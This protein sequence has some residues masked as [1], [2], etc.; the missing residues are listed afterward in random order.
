MFKHKTAIRR[1]TS[2][3]SDIS[4]FQ[5][6][7]IIIDKSKKYQLSR[8]II[9]DILTMS[10]NAINKTLTPLIIILLEQNTLGPI[11]LIK[12]ILR[13]Q[14]ILFYIK[15]KNTKRRRKKRC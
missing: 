12:T 14:T 4:T 3:Y 8:P 9:N 5:Y 6:Y 1:P 15:M 10:N 2:K 11:N 13:E 7:I